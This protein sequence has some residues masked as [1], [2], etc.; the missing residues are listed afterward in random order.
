[1]GRLQASLETLDDLLAGRHGEI[2]DARRAETE[3]LREQVAQSRAT[4]RV[5]LSGAGEAELRIDG[6]PIG[7]LTGGQAREAAAEN[8]G[9][10]AAAHDRANTRSRRSTPSASRAFTRFGMLGRSPQIS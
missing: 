1:M 2:S 9:G 10:G 5:E 3:S 6:E 4:L 7:A 8:E